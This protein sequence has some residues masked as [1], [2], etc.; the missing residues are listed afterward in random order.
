MPTPKAVLDPLLN[1]RLLEAPDSEAMDAVF[2]LRPSAKGSGL[3]PAATRA[4]VERLLLR[5]H[6]LTGATAIQVTV[7]DNIQS[8][9]VSAPAIL[10]KS[11]IG[12]KEIA[13]A[14]SNQQQQDLLIRPVARREVKLPK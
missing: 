13:S 5:A 6:K 3:T 1:Q 11:L 4:T 10:I 14:M 8:F 2:T 12:F 9:A 7:F